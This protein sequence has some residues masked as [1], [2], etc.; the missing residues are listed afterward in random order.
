MLSIALTVLSC[1]SCILI[2]TS[3]YK[4]KDAIYSIGDTIKPFS[5]FN[6]DSG[7]YVAYLVIDETD[8]VDLHEEITHKKHL[9]TQDVSVLK[10]MQKEWVFIYRERD[11]ATV[12]SSLYILKEGKLIFSSGIVLDKDKQG[13]Q[14]QEFG[15]IES[16]KLGKIV[17]VCKKFKP[18]KR[19]IIVI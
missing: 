14:S 8:F 10:E 17:E 15:W 12:T 3:S 19:P 7:E 9:K 5:D 4:N 1:S 6:F 2:N 11:L 13:L 18:V 16:V